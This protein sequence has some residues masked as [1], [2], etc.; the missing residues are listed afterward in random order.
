M[1]VSNSYYI[2]LGWFY[3]VYIDVDIVDLLDNV[4]RP[5]CSLGY[6]ARFCVVCACL[7]LS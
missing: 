1:C 2:M 5:M 6:L 7:E 4:Y 3:W